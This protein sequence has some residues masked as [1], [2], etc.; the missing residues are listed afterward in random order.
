[1]KK[2]KTQDK[3]KKKKKEI[4]A[5]IQAEKDANAHDKVLSDIVDGD[6]QL[7]KAETVD[8]SK[9]P[10]KSKLAGQIK[11]EKEQARI[12][13]QQSQ[14]LSDVVKDQKLKHV[15]TK[16]KNLANL[17]KDE[18]I[19]LIKAE[20]DAFKNE[21]ASNRAAVLGDIAQGAKNLKKN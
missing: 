12:D 10:E 17:S 16:E 2:T 20:R 18:L 4:A 8:K 3:S 21:E 7:K 11:E 13:E 15:D 5:E 1:L 6:Y 19:A 9:L 14:I